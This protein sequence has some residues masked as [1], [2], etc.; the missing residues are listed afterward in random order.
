MHIRL[1]QVGGDYV[2][3]NQDGSHTHS[4]AS[5]WADVLD[6]LW[7]DLLPTTAAMTGLELWRYED[8]A[9]YFVEGITDTSAGTGT[10]TPDPCTFLNIS[11]RDEDWVFGH[12]TVTEPSFATSVAS[13]KHGEVW[14]DLTNFIAALVGGTTSGSTL[15]CFV[16]S[17]P[18]GFLKHN[19]NWTIKVSDRIR[20]MRGY[21]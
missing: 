11:L 9:Y 5:F 12:V 4:L 13:K 8:G 14:E 3:S 20:R 7:L 2:I 15:G 1:D 10:E 16:V 19:P 17:K 21:I 6:A 18:G